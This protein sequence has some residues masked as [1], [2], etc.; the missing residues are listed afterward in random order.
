MEGMLVRQETRSGSPIVI[1]TETCS[2]SGTLEKSLK[3]QPSTILENF[4]LFSCCSDRLL[5]WAQLNANNFIILVLVVECLHDKLNTFY[6][7]AKYSYFRCIYGPIDGRWSARIS[8][9]YYLL[10]LVARTFRVHWHCSKFAIMRHSRF[11][12]RRWSLEMCML[13]AV[14]DAINTRFK[15]YTPTLWTHLLEC[16]FP[17][18]DKWLLSKL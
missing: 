10:S 7:C 1:P 14:Y 18:L 8:N 2:C 16:D 4:L 6:T 5:R 11:P 15:L 17:L 9:I 3:V 13:A 12:R